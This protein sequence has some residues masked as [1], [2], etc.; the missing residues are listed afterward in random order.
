MEKRTRAL[1]GFCLSVVCVK[2]PALTLAQTRDIVVRSFIWPVLYV[3][4]L[5]KTLFA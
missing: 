3:P 5:N 2:G 4:M 1:S